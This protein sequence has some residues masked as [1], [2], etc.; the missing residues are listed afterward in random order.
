MVAAAV[1]AT[2]VEKL[3]IL[4]ENVTVLQ[5]LMGEILT[6]S[7]KKK[8]NFYF[9]LFIFISFVCVYIQC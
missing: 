8:K 6:V 4:P 3:V 1:A 5:T 7:K 2:N 9:L